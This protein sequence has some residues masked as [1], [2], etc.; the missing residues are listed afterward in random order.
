MLAGFRNFLL[1]FIISLIIFSIIAFFVVNMVL[2]SIGV[3]TGIGGNNQDPVQTGGEEYV[4]D[5]GNDAQEN[6]NGS[7]F[8]MLFVGLDYAEIFYDFYDPDTVENLKQSEDGK[9]PGE[10]VTDGKYRRVSADTIL[11]M[12]ISK[13]RKEFVFTSIPPGTRI[14][15]EDETKNLSDIYED[16][17]RESFIDTIHALVGVPIDRYAFISMDKFPDVI[18]NLF[19]DGIEFNVPCDMVYDDYKGGLHIDIK[20]GVQNLD[21]DRVLQ[22]LRF[23]KYEDT[24]NSR[25]KTTVAVVREIMEELLIKFYMPKASGIYDDIE[26]ALVTDFLPSDLNANLD[27]IFSYPNFT[28][29]MLELPGRYTTIDEKLCFI[30]DEKGCLNTLAPYKR[31]SNQ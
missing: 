28:P 12:C 15:R 26:D 30:P 1:T 3:S 31:V 9:I 29:V 27:L 22:V 19:S 17:G 14:S 24:V 6:L 5:T 20:A 21:G 16:E 11:L 2:D 7:S 10:L 4:E 25:L 18:D 13:E 23:N 8:N